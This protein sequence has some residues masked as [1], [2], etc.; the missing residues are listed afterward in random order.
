MR[1]EFV[2][3]W[4]SKAAPH[5]VKFIMI[6]QWSRLRW[7]KSSILA[8]FLWVVKEKLVHAT[9]SANT[10]N[11]KH[12]KRIFT[13]ENNCPIWWLLSL[14][15]RDLLLHADTPT[16][17]ATSYPIPLVK[18]CLFILKRFFVFL[19]LDMAEKATSLIVI[20]DDLIHILTEL[21]KYTLNIRDLQSI[22]I[23][24]KFHK[25]LKT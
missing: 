9:T 15:T 12:Q 20:R 25:L 3:R 14:S 19:N 16:V 23:I 22:Q 5:G 10:H 18:Q 13:A 4:V 17:L 7:W 8:L 2:L 24:F 1:L 21:L 6:C 11:E